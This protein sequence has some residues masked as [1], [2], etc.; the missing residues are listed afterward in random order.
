MLKNSLGQN[1][2]RAWL[3]I[4]HASWGFLCSCYHMLS[5]TLVLSRL[6]LVECPR[7]LTCIA[8]NLMLAVVWGLVLGG[9]G[10]ISQTDYMQLLYVA[11]PSSQHGGLRVV[12]ILTWQLRAEVQVRWQKVE[13]A[14]PFL[15]QF[16]I[17]H[18]IPLAVFFVKPQACLDLGEGDRL[19]FSKRRMSKNLWPFKK[20]I[21]RQLLLLLPTD[22]ENDVQE[23]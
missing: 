12:K 11:C 8:Y 5:E 19:Y 13:A 14:L 16:C 9:R 1:L 6:Y 17:S 15:T 3:G 23:G 7:W 4:P 18:S 2:D 10:Y 22:D 20:N 21:H